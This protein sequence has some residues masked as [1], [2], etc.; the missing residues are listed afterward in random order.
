MYMQKKRC[1]GNNIEKKKIVVEWKYGCVKGFGSTEEAERFINQ[2]CKK[3]A[4][5]LEYSVSFLN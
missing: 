2:V 4:P 5:D 1:N 3:T